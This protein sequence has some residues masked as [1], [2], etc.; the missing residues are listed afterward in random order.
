M[1]LSLASLQCQPSLKPLWPYLWQ[2]APSYCLEPFIPSFHNWAF[3]E[4]IDVVEVVDVG[5][6]VVDDHGFTTCLQ[7]SFHSRM[8]GKAFILGQIACLM[9]SSPAPLGLCLWE[10]FHVL[11]VNDS[12]VDVAYAIDGGPL[13]PLTTKAKSKMSMAIPPLQ[14]VG[15]VVVEDGDGD[16]PTLNW[17]RHRRLRQSWW[18]SPFVKM[19]TKA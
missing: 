14:N 16:P 9:R 4:D 15:K 7:L 18:Q 10:I 8:P 1:I 5:E 13:L 11:E 17:W 19:L 3:A 2:L 12:V 6:A